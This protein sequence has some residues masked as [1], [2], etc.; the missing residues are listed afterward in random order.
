MGY[1]DA[2]RRGDIEA[3]SDAAMRYDNQYQASFTRI[4]GE[5][6]AAVAVSISKTAISV[7]PPRSF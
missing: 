7:F 5:E 1:L 4:G 3:T 6:V 2:R